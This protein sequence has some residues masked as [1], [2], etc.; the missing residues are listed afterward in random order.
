MIKNCKQCGTEFDAKTTWQEFCKDAHRVAYY[1]A[2][3]KAEEEKA[4]N[5]QPV[6]SLTGD[7]SGA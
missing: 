2:Q 6:P 5:S 1:R 4:Q 7:K 3:I